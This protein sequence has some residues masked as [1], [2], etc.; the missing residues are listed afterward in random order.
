MAKLVFDGCG[1]QF[2]TGPI[3]ICGF[4]LAVLEKNWLEKGPPP[5]T[6]LML[7]GMV[8]GKVS[9]SFG[10]LFH[11]DDLDGRTDGRTDRWRQSMMSTWISTIVMMLIARGAKWQ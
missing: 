2:G 11:H 10:P 8:G 4:Y 6:K 7:L 1:S 3:K 9:K 5:E